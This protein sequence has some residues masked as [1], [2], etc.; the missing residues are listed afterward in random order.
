[1]KYEALQ[2][3]GVEPV[4]VLH[5][6]VG[7]VAVLGQSQ[8]KR[9]VSEI[10]VEINHQHLPGIRFGQQSAQL[11]HDR[12]NATSPLGTDERQYLGL[13]YLFPFPAAAPDSGHGIQQLLGIQRLDQIFATA[14]SH[15]LDDQVRLGLRRHREY[16]GLGS[17][18]VDSFGDQRGAATVEVEIQQAYV[19][20]RGSDPV[21][22]RIMIVNPILRQMPLKPDQG[23]GVCEQL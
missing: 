12:G 21:E 20:R 10:V 23:S 16:R 1:M 8:I 6:L 3:L 7:V 18:G 2:K 15:G 19:G 11:G 17:V 9:G 13:G 22:N 4:R 14:A 5:Q